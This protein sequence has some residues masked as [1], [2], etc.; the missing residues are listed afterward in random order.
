MLSIF[1]IIMLWYNIKWNTKNSLVSLWKAFGYRP[2]KT[3]ISIRTQNVI[4]EEWSLIKQCRWLESPNNLIRWPAAARKYPY[5]KLRPIK[6]KKCITFLLTHK[7]RG[8]W[9]S[10]RFCVKTP[11][12]AAR[13]S[14]Q[15]IYRD[16]S[17]G[18]DFIRSNWKSF[19]VEF[20]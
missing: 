5:V 10:V 16:P 3:Q 6:L 17:R 20:R 2:F 19:E 4:A 18:G 11:C 7:K 15:L 12:W 14:E 13:C 1:D 9:L 8:I